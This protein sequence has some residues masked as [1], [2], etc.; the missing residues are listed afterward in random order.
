MTNLKSIVVLF[1]LLA[2]IGCATTKGDWQKATQLN[3]VTAY[4]EFLQK[5]P[6]SKFIREA[7]HRIEELEW[8]EAQKLD[9]IEAYQWF[10][11]KYH[12]SKF[13]AEARA[14]IKKLQAEE[15]LK[16]IFE[17]AKTPLQLEG[18]LRTHPDMAKYIV[19]RLEQAIL[20]EIRN[21]GVGN[22]L[23]IQEFTPQIDGV[24]LS[25]TISVNDKSVIIDFEFP[26]DQCL[27]S[28]SGPGMQ[29][30]GF[31]RYSETKG[32]PNEIAVP[33]ED[34]KY[35]LFAL[36]NWQEQGGMTLGGNY[37]IHRFDGAIE[38]N[39]YRF[40]GMGN[41]TNRLTFALIENVGYIYLR[42][43]GMVVLKNGEEVKLGD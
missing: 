19:P 37:G 31:A 5:H 43:K 16:R 29:F 8:N 14:R 13:A 34:L 35:I 33:K 9:T 22:R 26:G 42:G 15:K 23:V 28:A 17:R 12:Q 39:G 32:I 6:E 20:Q 7:K 10:L 21:K 40:V 41:K 30:T 36:P 2:L 38:I 1:C 27:I 24:T 18:S 25:A 4:K 11:R 3:T